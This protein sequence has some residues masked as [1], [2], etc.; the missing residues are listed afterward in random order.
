MLIDALKFAN[1]L[2]SLL[3]ILLLGGLIATAVGAGPRVLRTV[4]LHVLP[5][6]IAGN[7][8]AFTSMA[9][10]RNVLAVLGLVTVLLSFFG[11]VWIRRVVKEDRH[12]V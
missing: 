8:I 9:A 4:A 10:Q 12:S 2:S 3:L 5:V 1:A 7:L 11:W 6:M